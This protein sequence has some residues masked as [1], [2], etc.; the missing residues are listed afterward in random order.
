MIGKILG[1]RY[2]IVEKIGG[3]GMAIVYKAK[4]KLLNRFVAVKILR[5]ELLDDHEFVKKFGV[6]AQAAAS[7][8]HTNIVSIYDI[9]EQDDIHYIVMEY[10]DGITLKEVIVQKG[11][12]PWEHALKIAEQ[13]CSALE[14]AHKNNIIHR[15]IK[16]HNILIKKDGM[17]KVAD[18]GI[19]RAITSA[20]VTVDA[21]TIGSVHYISPEQA[22]GG[23]TNE[24]SDIYSLGIVIYEM[25]T[26]KVPFDGENS[27]AVAIKHI[28]E[29]AQLVTN[30]N[31]DIPNCIQ[32]IVAKAISKE[33]I[34]RYDSAEE[35]HT[36]IQ[37]ALKSPNE[38]FVNID[39]SDEYPTQ[40]V[41]IVKDGELKVGRKRSLKKEDK[42]AIIAAAITAVL[43]IIIGFYVGQGFF[44]NSV[45]KSDGLEVPNLIGQDYQSVKSEYADGK[46]ITVINAGEQYSEEYEKGL[47]ISQNPNVGEKLKMPTNIEVVVSL[48]E[49]KA[50]VPDVKNKDYRLAGIDIDN[51]GFKYEIENEFND[52]VPE[53]YVISQSPEGLTEIREGETVVI[54]VSKGPEIKIIKVPDLMGMN[55]DEAKN[56]IL[57][58]GLLQGEVTRQRNSKPKGTIIGQSIPAEN[59]VGEKT[60]INLI[61]SS[62]GVS[63]T[64]SGGSTQTITIKLP[65]NREKIEVKVIANSNSGNNV[66]YNKVHNK[67][68]SPVDV[69]LSG[70]GI[71]YI[72]VFFDGI[73]AG[74]DKID[75]GG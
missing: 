56:S 59:E 23:Y 9:G 28:Q 67:A 6:E 4:C 37:K 48:G 51:A 38:R 11:F 75:F 26:G 73:L 19:A 54:F 30:I 55:E 60:K 8:S 32:L 40:K 68:D 36:D 45:G 47:I 22:R 27:V 31:A 74:E 53:G 65:Q 24:K 18:F 64:V 41:P 69:K 43:I 35:M 3:G 49:K 5:R 66:V 17:A 50:T 58:L 52:R 20:T 16:P 57:R 2:E 39:N 21:S 71:A 12:L 14:H 13:I 62:G 70:K 25:L 33:Q 7:L 10:I 46:K 34:R 44:N 15:D 72:Q 63:D 42:N 29:K 1:N 61:V